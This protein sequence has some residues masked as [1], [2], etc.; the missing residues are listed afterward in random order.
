MEPELRIEPKPYDELDLNDVAKIV[1]DCLSAMRT[2]GGQDITYGD[3]AKRI[4]DYGELTK[5]KFIVVT[6]EALRAFSN[7]NGKGRIHQN[8][9]TVK[10]LYLYLMANAHKLDQ[11]VRSI[12]MRTENWNVLNGRDIENQHDDPR[13]RQ[14]LL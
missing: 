4:S 9:L 11:G 10:A 8:N 14:N 1:H 3:I 6:E 2:V 13:S 7:R 12:M 5:N